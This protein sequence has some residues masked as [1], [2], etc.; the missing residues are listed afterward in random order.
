MKVYL[1]IAGILTVV[2]VARANAQAPAGAGA[3]ADRDPSKISGVGDNAN[4][5]QLISQQHG[6]MQF[7]GKVVMDGTRALWGSNS[8]AVVFCDGKT[9]YNTGTD[10][11]GGFVILASDAKLP[12]SEIVKTKS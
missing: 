10:A 8:G 3:P 4:L 11:K 1:L 12:D 7:A 9:R 6:S 2:C 5:S